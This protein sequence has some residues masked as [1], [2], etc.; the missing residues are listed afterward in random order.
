[1]SLHPCF[2]LSYYILL[3]WR[4]STKSKSQDIEQEGAGEGEHTLIVM[5]VVGGYRQ[6]GFVQGSQLLLGGALLGLRVA[7]QQA[8]VLSFRHAGSLLFYLWINSFARSSCVCACCMFIWV[9]FHICKDT[10]TCMY[11]VGS[12]PAVDIPWL[13]GNI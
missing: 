7:T 4:H 9:H 2:L 8:R 5:E 6:M 1:M 3:C 11:L 12:L 10:D 13:W